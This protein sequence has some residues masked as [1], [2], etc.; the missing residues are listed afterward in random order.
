MQNMKNDSRNKGKPYL[1]F[2]L[3]LAQF[4]KYVYILTCKMESS[5]SEYANILIMVLSGR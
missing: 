4:W 2:Y 3:L 5:V 1:K